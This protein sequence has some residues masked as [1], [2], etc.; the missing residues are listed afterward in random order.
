MKS[1]IIVTC[2]R[3]HF[4]GGRADL[5][6]FVGR[7]GLVLHPRHADSAVVR[8]AR[9]SPT[10]LGSYLR[11]AALLVGCSASRLQNG[12]RRPIRSSAGD[13]TGAPERCDA[14]GVL[15]PTKR[16]A[17]AAAPVRRGP[18][19]R[20]AHSARSSADR[21]LVRW[22]RRCSSLPRGAIARA[23][24]GP[25][26]RWSVRSSCTAG[27]STSASRSSTTCTWCASSR[28]AARSSST[29]SRTCRSARRWSCPRTAS[30]R[31]CTRTPS[32]ASCGRS[33]RPA[34]S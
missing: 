32:C 12:P 26:R 5:R 11:G 22:L 6:D 24:S 28:S 19:E 23:W 3:R 33:T 30:P 29:T 9:Q 13:P 2:V 18:P 21:L 10:R 17:N 16:C 14:N 1:S 15:A 20:R 31:P 4:V 8:R 25:S 34:R 7:S 27:R